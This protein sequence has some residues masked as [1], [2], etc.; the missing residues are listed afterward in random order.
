M[1][2]RQS[3]QWCHGI[4]MCAV[5]DWPH[6]AVRCGRNRAPTDRPGGR[7]MSP[8]SSKTRLVRHPASGKRQAGSC[9]AF[10][11]V[12]P[13]Q[14]NGSRSPTGGL[15]SKNVGALGTRSTR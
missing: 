14:Q 10:S 8:F 13:L 1:C 9:R 6:F 15:N 11:V 5:S 12:G 4:I 7:E 2:R 3:A